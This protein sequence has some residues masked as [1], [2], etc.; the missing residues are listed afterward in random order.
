VN[1]EI[2]NEFKY[3]YSLSL[4]EVLILEWLG[5]RKG[6]KEVTG[7]QKRREKK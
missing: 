7:K 1:R 4:I 5:W 6:S 3:P 2:S